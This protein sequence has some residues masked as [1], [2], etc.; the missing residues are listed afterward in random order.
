M[1]KSLSFAIVF[2][3]IF[4][5]AIGTALAFPYSGA[6]IAN[7]QDIFSIQLSL[8]ANSGSGLYLYDIHDGTADSLF[9]LDSS[10]AS[11]RNVYFTQ[12]SGNWYAGLNAGDLT[13]E[14]NDNAEFGFYFDD[15]STG[16][17][18]YLV[19][20]ISPNDVYDLYDSNTNML[21]RTSDVQ[22]SVAP[23]PASMLLL[24][25]GLV[26]LAGLRKKFRK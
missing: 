7:D 13:L 9:L 19:T 3:F 10:F 24:G 14:L 11:S 17:T 25:F 21:V 1:K 15:G 2:V 12:D 5:L 22:M 26:G 20:E 4:F 18:S 8:A 6:W 16:F 23:E